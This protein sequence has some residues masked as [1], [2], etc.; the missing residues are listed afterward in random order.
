MDELDLYLDTYLDRAGRFAAVAHAVPDDRW[1]A[2]SPCEKW[3]TADVL[4]H[5][6]DTQRDFLT[7]HDLDPGPRP[8]GAPAAV[9]DEH[10]AAVRQAVAGA[11]G[12]PFEG[13]FGP[14]TIGDTLANFY[15]FDLVVHRWDL[16]RGGGLDTDFTD[17]EMDAVEASLGQFGEHVYDEGVCAP[18]VAVPADA[19][20]QRRL[21]ALL[22]RRED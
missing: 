17:D 7:R 8:A 5:V 1:S 10:V 18:A 6:V 15:G 21:L 2:Q 16:A 11:L 12:R 4:D 20:R 9:W 22:G 19:S 14:T 3:T 13:Y